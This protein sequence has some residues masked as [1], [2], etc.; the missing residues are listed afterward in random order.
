MCRISLCGSN[1]DLLARTKAAREAKLAAGLLHPGATDPDSETESTMPGTVGSTVGPTDSVVTFSDNATMLEAVIRAEFIKTSSKRVADDQYSKYSWGR[2]SNMD[3]NYDLNEA[4]VL[5]AGNSLEDSLRSA[6]SLTPSQ[7]KHATIDVV[8]KFAGVLPHELPGNP[9][10]IMTDFPL[11]VVMYLLTPIE[12]PGVPHK[13]D[14]RMMEFERK[15]LASGEYSE[16]VLARKAFMT[17]DERQRVGMRPPPRTY[18]TMPRTT[19]SHPMPFREH[20]RFKQGVNSRL[21]PGLRAVDTTGETL[22]PGPRGKRRPI[23]PVEVVDNMLTNPQRLALS[24]P[25][26]ESFSFPRTFEVAQP[27]PHFHV[28]SR[29]QMFVD[30]RR[31]IDAASVTGFMKDFGAG[32]AGE[33]AKPLEVLRDEGVFA[34]QSAPHRPQS[35]SRRSNLQYAPEYISAEHA[36]M[37]WDLSGAMHPNRRTMD[38][39]RNA[40]LSFLQ[41][42]VVPFWVPIVF[43]TSCPCRKP[44]VT[45]CAQF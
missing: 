9:F 20:P 36:R 35:P 29:V 28:P 43:C 23:N 25:L 11:P 21:V 5:Q 3:F 15:L 14:D 32:T 31:R 24:A 6:V 12:L 34:S 2:D 17:L 40:V 27:D 33:V 44:Q 16:L 30:P 45:D 1:Q 10:Q 41:L 4:S 19:S 37:Q 8:A 22:I 13:E 26:P 38:A 42:A 18:T 39:V 7:L